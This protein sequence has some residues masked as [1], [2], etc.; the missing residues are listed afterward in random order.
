[1]NVERHKTILGPEHPQTLSAM[2]G[3]SMAYHYSGR[4]RKALELAQ[5]TLELRRRVL[6][7]FHIDTLVSMNDVAA[8]HLRLKEIG[9]A[10]PLFK[11]TLAAMKVTLDPLHPERLNTTRLLAET[12]MAAE[13]PEKAVP[14][15][16][17]LVTQYKTAYG[18]DYPATE[19]CIDTL[20]RCYVDLGLCDKAAALLASIQTGGVNRPIEVGQQ[21]DTRERRYRD[22][23]RRVKPAAD[24]YHQVLAAKNA[25]HPDTLAARQ[26]LA[27]VLRDQD[28]LSGAA[29]HLAAVL[30][31]RQHLAIDQ[32][33]TQICRLELGTTRL[34]QK[35]Y[36]E[37]EPLFLEAYA[38][39]KQHET[40]IRE[41]KSRT[42]EAIDRL[43]QLY[44]AWDKKDKADEWRKKLDA[45]K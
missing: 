39:L 22:L 45:V 29:Y 8:L 36:A 5:K 41:L 6:V 25:D 7:P 13:Q 17:L 32:P 43:V 1:V 10:L 9:K 11:E 40:N 12:Y 16:E 20:I 14:I 31:A 26:T 28:R 3:L 18:V 23:I 44:V 30:D 27:V 42:A 4:T 38:G 21:Q 33:D 34:Q 2:E 24:A 37:A 35:K 19:G 15:Q